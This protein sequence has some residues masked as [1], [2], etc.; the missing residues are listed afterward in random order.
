MPAVCTGECSVRYTCLLKANTSTV[1]NILWKTEAKNKNKNH[2][3][4]EE[5]SYKIFSSLKCCIALYERQVLTA[6]TRGWWY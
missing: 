2:W 3:I 1:Y 5:N 4:I 6:L